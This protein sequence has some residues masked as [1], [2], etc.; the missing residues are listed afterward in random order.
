M[1]N[2]KGN[3]KALMGVVLILSGI[4]FVVSKFWNNSHGD[5][6][7]TT[8]ET[9][10]IDIDG[11]LSKSVGT[12]A[13]GIASH[14][15]I[16]IN[17]IGRKNF[18]DVNIDNDSKEKILNANYMDNQFNP[19]DEKIHKSTLILNRCNAAEKAQ[20]FA[21][22]FGKQNVTVAIEEREA[23]NG[24][25]YNRVHEFFVVLHSKKADFVLPNTAYEPKIG[26]YLKRASDYPQL[27]YVK[28]NNGLW[29]TIR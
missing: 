18:E 7:E 1:A 5:K 27:K 25:N 16:L 2:F 24:V 23:E 12:C 10:Q 20:M 22:H 21:S 26:D 3:Y 6:I 28:S 13:R 14:A 17:K 19:L 4:S 9:K 11:L 8:P 29:N 15:Q